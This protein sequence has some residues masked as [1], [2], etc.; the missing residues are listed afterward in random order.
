MRQLVLGLGLWIGVV[1]VALGADTIKAIIASP[2]AFDGR[3]VMVSG[4]VRAVRLKVSQ[5]GNPY[6][7]FYL[8]DR[9][10]VRVF[11]FGQPVIA[12]GQHIKVRG[13]FSADKHVGRST[14]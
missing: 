2:T 4:T 10:C 8:C 3:H 11:T 12:D 1:G 5:R 9:S 13:T 6:E 7:T 14:R